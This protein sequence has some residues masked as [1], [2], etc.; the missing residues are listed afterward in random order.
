M[1]DKVNREQAE[2]EVENWLDKKK[3]FQETRE[4]YKEHIEIITE[5]V[6][7][8]ALILNEKSE[9]EHTLLFP[10]GEG[11][12]DDSAMI[13]KLTYRLR[14]TDKLISPHMRGVKSDDVDGRLNALIAAITTQSK[15]VISNLDSG[16]K[17]ISTAIG[18]FF[19]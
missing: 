5:A 18:I 17:R 8:G 15:S 7:N 3:V 6:I 16:D 12:N 1:L 4:R 19:M 11:K 10:L 13:E 14:I 9:F 2:K